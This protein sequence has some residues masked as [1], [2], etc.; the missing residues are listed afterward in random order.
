MTCGIQNVSVVICAY[1]EARW[2]DLVAAVKS[3]QCQTIPPKDIVVVIDHKPGLLE[4]ARAQLPSVVAVEN[5]E[6]R[7]L[8]G[9]RNSGVA[10]AQGEVIAFLDDDAIAAPDWLER[11]GAAYTAPNIVGVGGAIEPFWQDGRPRWFPS[12]FNW[13]VGCTYQGMPEAT[14]PVRNL[15][16]ANMSFRREVLAMVG[17]FRSGIGRIGII[18][19][20]CEETELCIRARQRSPDK[21]FL[22]EPGSRVRHRVPTSRIQWGYF[23]SR[24]YA[25]GLSKARVSL[26]VGAGDGLA[27]ERTYTFRTLPRGVIRGVADTFLRRDPAGL[28]RAGAIIAGLL[29]TTAGYVA[30]TVSRWSAFRQ[31]TSNKGEAIQRD[32]VL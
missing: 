3:V 15:I 31:E 21:V 30:G 14:A 29:I 13:V 1:T 17:G 27:S 7:G 26:L 5:V 4:R 6:P 8:S 23:R 19:T 2:D 20:G 9:A 12:E 16:G 22:Y 11:L 25:E 18:P 32:S 28:A 24:C 10:V